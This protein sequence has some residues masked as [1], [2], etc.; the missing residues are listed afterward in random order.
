VYEAIYGPCIHC[1]AGKITA[2]SYRKPSEAAPAEKIKQVIWSDLW[3][4][5]V[6]LVGGYTNYVISI[7]EH[8][9]YGCTVPLT[10]K[11]A[12]TV[13][14]GLMGT[15][16]LYSRH[17]HTVERIVTDS[18]ATFRKCE[19]QLGMMGIELVHTPPYQHAQRIE[20]YVRTIK[21]RMRT[22]RAAMK[23]KLPA[24]LDGYL[25]EAVVEILNRMP[26]TKHQL[27][28]P[29]IGHTET[30]A[31]RNNRIVTRSRWCT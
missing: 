30:G 20:R 14:A 15:V 18:E 31:V 16:S 5:E 6:K 27:A 21:D 24:K 12:T 13:L 28:T 9:D 29:T 19:W 8:S 17:G 22:M 4:F 26:G 25:L 1:I 23:V 7:D 2:P 10:T 11:S 3:P